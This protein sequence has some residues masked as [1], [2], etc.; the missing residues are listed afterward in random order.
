MSDNM[1]LSRRKILGGVGAVGAAGAAAGLGTTALFSD[2]ESFTNNSI[3]AGT[4]DMK[5]DWEEHY[6]FPQLY[7]LGDPE[8][9]LTT[10]RSDPSSLNNPVPF[11]PGVEADMDSDPILWVEGE[12]GN[13][14]VG[15]YM[16][17]TSIEAFPDTD[18]DGVQDF[19]TANPP[20]DICS[21]LTDV[22]LDEDGL[23]ADDRTTN[24]A[25]SDGDPLINLQDVKPGDFGEV[26]LSFH[27]CDNPGY[28]WLNA[29][30]FSAAENGQNEAEE[31]EG[32]DTDDTVELL[33]EIETAW[34][35][36]EDCD[37]LT[38]AGD[39]GGGSGKA[40]IVF[41]VDGSGSIRGD[42]RPGIEDAITGNTMQGP[43]VAQQ[44]QNQGIDAQYAIVDFFSGAGL[45]LDL[46]ANV[47]DV[48]TAF[49]DGTASSFSGASGSGGESLSNAILVA[50]GQK[51]SDA[52][53]LRQD[54]KTIYVGIT[55]EPDQSTSQEKT[56]AVNLINN[57]DAAF[58]GIAESQSQISELVNGVNQSRF[59]T[60]Q[61]GNISGPLQDLAGFAGG[62]T[63]GEEIF[64]QDTLRNALSLL[65]SGEGIPLDGPI[66]DNGDDFNEATDP[67]TADSRGCFETTPTTNCIGFSWWVPT[68]VGNQIQSDSVSFDLGFTA[69]Q[70]RNSNG[71]FAN[72]PDLQ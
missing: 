63:G 70:C 33:D 19:D 37:N 21:T 20:D 58:L 42:E 27:L 8:D 67:P 72:A 34:W 6:S 5:V 26:T 2:E 47:G 52:V 38:D 14:D 35:Y 68:D 51:G 54:A 25:T 29:Q 3:T 65:T 39:G 48:A 56:D 7:G 55:D 12:D 24:A 23:S 16:D 36:D 28:M 10:T 60:F 50:G 41:V 1:E 53:S 4:L 11:P 30:N 46:T 59:S 61:E 40:D 43:G 57:N 44:I 69:I 66:G 13:S 64:Y 15:A 17:N 31:N 49:G 62:V 9:G 45:D 71:S 22:G 18:D 32:G